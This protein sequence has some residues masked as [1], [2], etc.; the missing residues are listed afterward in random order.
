[1]YF[2]NPP[3]Y[4]GLHAGRKREGRTR[5]Y[6]RCVDVLRKLQEPNACLVFNDLDGRYRVN[7]GTA[8]K[9]VVIIRTRAKLLRLRAIRPLSGCHPNLV[10]TETGRKLLRHWDMQI[11]M[12]SRR[13]DV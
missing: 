3:Q 9:D 10:I 1:M 11:H 13:K 2:R 8:R 4:R 6:P 12:V 5:L 7:G